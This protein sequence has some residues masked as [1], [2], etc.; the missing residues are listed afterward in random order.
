MLPGKKTSHE[1]NKKKK[2]RAYGKI[3]ISP[4]HARPLTQL[5]FALLITNE[6]PFIILIITITI[7]ANHQRHNNNTHLH[8]SC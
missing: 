4:L 1:L 2:T 5:L 6:L 3:I 8:D 7:V